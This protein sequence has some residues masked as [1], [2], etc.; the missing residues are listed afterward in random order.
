MIRSLTLHNFKCFADQQINF[1]PL[2]LLVGA[3][4]SG[5]SSVIQALLLLRQSYLR[6]VL[7]GQDTKLLLNGKLASIGTVLDVFYQGYND[8]ELRFELELDDRES[9]LFTFG[10]GVGA[11]QKR[12]LNGSARYD[13]AISLFQDR[14]NYLNA[15]RLGPKLLFPMQEGDRDPYDT[16]IHGEYA[17]H[18]VGRDRQEPL[19]NSE[20][21]YRNE[22]TGEVSIELYQQ[23]QYW[24][25]QIIPNFE[26]DLTPIEAS[27][28]VQ[29]LFG[30]L[31]GQD[32]VRPSN[33]G[34][35]L[36]Y[37]LPIIVAALV[38]PAGSLLIVENPE[39]HLH[40]ASQSAMGRFL[41][42]VAAAGVQVV[43][44]THSDHILNGVR[45]AVRKGAWGRSIGADQ[46]SIQ[47]FIPANE[48]GPHRIETP[49]LYPSGG[50][51][52]WPSGFFDQIDRDIDELL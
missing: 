38:A 12:V 24:M 16:G 44:E 2:T 20:L 29:A 9:A 17:V 41:A 10:R 33:I 3:N 22:E 13:P 4:A 46:V 52:P 30:N 47:F 50:I 45:V 26:M 6:G 31:P 1:A 40:P 23:T 7:T 34:F 43:V 19:S 15:E 5:K 39:A 18:I 28:Q 8:L 48:R 21:A 25:R 36:I 37:T 49:R 32:L 35:G 42:H 51:T 11:D 14:F 27:D